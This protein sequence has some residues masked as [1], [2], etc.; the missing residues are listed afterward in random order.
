MKIKFWTKE[1]DAILREYYHQYSTK[2]LIKSFLPNR[3][4]K[5]IWDRV[6]RLGISKKRTLRGTF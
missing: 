5:Q 1:E 3:T 4:A 6:S 2:I